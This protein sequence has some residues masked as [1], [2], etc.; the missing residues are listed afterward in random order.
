MLQPHLVSAACTAA[1]QF[2]QPLHGKNSDG[3]SSPAQQPCVVTRTQLLTEQN[4]QL[5][6]AVHSLPCH[7]G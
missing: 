1:L 6:G 7:A 4:L 2:W 3:V 5:V